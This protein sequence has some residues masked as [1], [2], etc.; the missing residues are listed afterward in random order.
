MHTVQDGSNLVESC[1]LMHF[2][3]TL[4][5]SGHDYAVLFTVVSCEH[6][7][8]KLFFLMSM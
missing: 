7:K 2:P 5:R 6:N 4:F 3:N 8:F 1:M